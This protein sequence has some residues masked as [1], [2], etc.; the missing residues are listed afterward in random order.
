MCSAVWG[1]K[2]KEVGA[3]ACNTP[4]NNR[5]NG[6]HLWWRGNVGAKREAGN[7]N[8]NDYRKTTGS[9]HAV[10]RVLVPLAQDRFVAR[11]GTAFWLER[12]RQWQQKPE[13][14]D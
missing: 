13:D 7:E 1:M 14:W 3:F 5:Q 10:A 11:N 4:A 8:G 9:L 6:A 12:Y 2:E